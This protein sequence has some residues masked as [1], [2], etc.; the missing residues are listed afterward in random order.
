[1]RDRHG[2]YE[3]TKRCGFLPFAD[4]PRHTDQRIELALYLS[5][6]DETDRAWLEDIGWRIRDSAPVSATP[7]AYQSYIQQSRGEFGWAKPSCVR[8]QVAWLSDRTPCYLASGKPV[9][10]QHTG[11]SRF[12]PSNSGMFRYTT[13]EEAAKCFATLAADYD[14]HARLARQLAEEHFD[15]AQMARRVLDHAL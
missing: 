13:L 9:V 2:F 5:S 4:L 3:N 7:A 11:P 1:M 6:Y 14:H 12:L 8:Y 10:L 15:A